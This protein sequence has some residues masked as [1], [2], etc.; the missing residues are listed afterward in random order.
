MLELR[1]SSEL[2]CGFYIDCIAE[3]TFKKTGAL[4]CSS[5]IFLLKLIFISMNLHKA[6]H[7]IMLPC[8]GLDS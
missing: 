5:K 4:I 1:F 3:T 2:E 6:L 7:G 8:L